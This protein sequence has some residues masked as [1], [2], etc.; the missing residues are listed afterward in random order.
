MYVSLPES[1]RFAS[2]P[3][4]Q[5]GYSSLIDHHTADQSVEYD[6]MR[7]MR[8]PIKLFQMTKKS[9]RYIEI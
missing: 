1:T 6:Q 5:P 4:A 2:S 9:Q 8:V 7:K 3:P